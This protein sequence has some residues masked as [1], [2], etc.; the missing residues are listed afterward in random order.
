[1]NSLISTPTRITS[2][3]STAIDHMYSNINYVS[4]CGTLNVNIADHLPIF[5]VKKK[6]RLHNDYI[7]VSCRTFPDDQADKFA[8]DLRSQMGLISFDSGDPNII[9]QNFYH[10]VVALLNRYCLARTVRIRD[11]SH[12]YID[13]ELVLLMKRR[14]TAFRRVRRYHLPEDWAEARRLRSEV[15]TSLRRAKRK[16]ILDQL[17]SA[18]GDSKKFWHI[19]GESFLKIQTKNIEEVFTDSE[20][21]L[22]KGKDAANEINNYF[23]LVSQK[24]SSKFGPVIIPTTN[25]LDVTYLE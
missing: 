15:Q 6:S 24:L 14:D 16:F 20:C 4:V 23:C 10:I 7:E 3:S 21:K 19:I 17:G 18:K 12:S 2:V 8:A 13:A 22:V 25:V 11:K 1:M 5:L 9:W